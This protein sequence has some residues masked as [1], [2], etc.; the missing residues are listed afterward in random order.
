VIPVICFRPSLA[1]ALRAF[2]S[3]REWTLTLDPAGIVSAW[4][5]WSWP[6]WESSESDSASSTVGWFVGVSS[7]SSS[8]LDI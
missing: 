5:P 6:A 1:S 2:F 4:S 3:P 7:G 8:I